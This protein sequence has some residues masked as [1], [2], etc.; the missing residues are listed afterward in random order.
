MQAENTKDLYERLT[1][2]G[3]KTDSWQSDL[4]VLKTPEAL[5]VIEA[6]E[7][8]GGITNRSEFVSQKDGRRWIEL[9]FAYSPFWKE[10]GRGR[11]TPESAG[12]RP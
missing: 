1:E 3:C 9:P 12:M 11:E 8:E 6:F 5:A 4:Y 2:A 10:R 7:A